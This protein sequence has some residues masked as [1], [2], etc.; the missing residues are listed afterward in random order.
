MAQAKDANP[1]TLSDRALDA[2]EQARAEINSLRDRI[3]TLMK[4]RV[5]P[6]LSGAAGD[7]EDMAHA[8]A[9]AMRRQKSAVVHNIRAQPFVAVGTAALAGLVLGLILRR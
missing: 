9:E 2:M 7:A 3:E 5:G 4:E 1:E 8:A 6:A